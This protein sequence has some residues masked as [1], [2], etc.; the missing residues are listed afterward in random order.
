MNGL[1]LLAIVCG[2]VALGF[3]L[4]RRFPPVQGQPLR[5]TKGSISRLELRSARPMLRVIAGG[6]ARKSAGG[7]AD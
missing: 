7:R 1:L 2:A 3:G 5:R 4:G 6:R